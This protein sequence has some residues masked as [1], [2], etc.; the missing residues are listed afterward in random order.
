MQE[1]PGKEEAPG[2]PYRGL[3]VWV[4][5][6]DLALD[7]FQM[8][9]GMAGPEPRAM[10]RALIDSSS[11]VP[12]AVARGQSSGSATQ[13]IRC[14]HEA[15]SELAALETHLLLCAETGHVTP[16]RVEACAGRIRRIRLLASG[17]IRRLRFAGAPPAAAPAREKGS[18]LLLA[19]LVAA[20]LGAVGL[21]FLQVGTIHH[22]IAARVRDRDQ[23]LNVAESGALAVKRWFDAPITGAPSDPSTARRLFLGALDLRDPGPFDRTRRL[24]DLDGDPLTPPV[25]AD[26]SPGRELYRQG[27]EI[28]PGLPHLD[29]FHKPFRGSR[30]LALLG[31]EEGPDLILEDSP[32]V[33]DLLDRM[34]AELFPRQDLTGRVERIEIYAPPTVAGPAPPEARL[35]I[36]TVKVTAARYRRLAREGGVTVAPPGS[37][38]TGRAVV[39]MGLA[40]IPLGRPPRGP[41]E[42]C[43]DLEA[44]GRLN[45]RWGP[46]LA[47]GD[48]RLAPLPADLHE[49]VA[50]GFPYQSPYRHIEGPGSGD[51]L[52]GWLADPDPSVEDPWLLVAA[53]GDIA[54]MEAG[55]DQPLPFDPGA[56]IDSDHSNLF[57]RAGGVGCAA[58]DY[59]VWKS[60]AT[61]ALAGD[62]RVHYFSFD[63]A[64]GLFRERGRGPERSVRDWT[65]GREG[66]FFFDTVDGSR[67][68]PGNLTPPVLVSGGD[69]SAAGMIFLNAESL[70]IDGARG[71]RRLVL[72]PGEPFVDGDGD[73]LYDPGELFVNLGYPTLLGA[74]GPAGEFRKDSGAVQ[75]LS[76][77]SAQGETYSV[78]TTLQRDAR[79]L[80][81]EAE[82][83]FAGLIVNSGDIVAQGRAVF[84][85]S[86]VAGRSV[87]QRSPG[88]DTPEIYYD[89]R[90]REGAWPP[91][92][93]AMPRTFVTFWQTLRP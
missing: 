52:A 17:L 15:L 23:L 76:A 67:P 24:L 5:A 7:I 71:A 60:V 4:E 81:L 42:S 14:L 16:D 58:F 28:E 65:H 26:G 87:T 30:E 46:V 68:R 10:G 64:S 53:G 56:P 36:A 9:R 80:P 2:P 82:V 91:A 32:G 1:S 59:E 47:A 19:I 66:L 35:G 85:G 44:T 69:W 41:L 88:A 49:T 50:S 25:A 72:P 77:E 55:A 12:V 39:R 18:A 33:V 22:R 21:V 54:G 48:V 11:R 74:A 40:E 62:R 89:P 63:A 90:I 38:A 57:Q 6:F 13:F 31:P 92:E 83:N 86:L 79:G 84:H 3:K 43:G 29:L 93:I 34:N 51:D 20:A 61:A 8:T 78:S 70:E 73:G 27:R 37:E 75:S 45:A